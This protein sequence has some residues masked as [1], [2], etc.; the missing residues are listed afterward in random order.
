MQCRNDRNQGENN[1]QSDQVRFTNDSGYRPQCCN[2]GH[3]CTVMP[4][5]VFVM[6][7]LCLQCMLGPRAFTSRHL[8]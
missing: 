4:I 5:Y 2:Y 7:A 8:E 1:G 3:R 6:Q